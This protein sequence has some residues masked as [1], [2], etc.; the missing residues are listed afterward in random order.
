MHTES[1]WS[2]VQLPQ[3]AGNESS[4]YCAL[5]FN[6]QFILQ[7]CISYIPSSQYVYFPLL[8]LNFLACTSTHHLFYNNTKI[9]L[10]ILHYCVSKLHSSLTLF[11]LHLFSAYH[12]SLV[13]SVHSKY[14]TKRMKITEPVSVYTYTSCGSH[15]CYALHVR[16][17]AMGSF[18]LCLYAQGISIICIHCFYVHIAIITYFIEFFFHTPDALRM[19]HY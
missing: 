19:S 5:E 12:V 9:S 18:S 15:C 6:C 10:C 16:L 17:V 2:T 11:S 1:V 4:Y 13:L 3:D 7:L 8:T 14:C